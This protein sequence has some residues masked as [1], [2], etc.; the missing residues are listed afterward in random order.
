MCAKASPQH[1]REHTPAQVFTHVDPAPGKS[2]TRWRGDNPAS[3]AVHDPFLAWLALK[4]AVQKHPFKISELWYL[5]FILVEHSTS[6]LD[7]EDQ[8]EQ[9]PPQ[10]HVKT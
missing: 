4:W 7:V 2:P 8:Q 10:N 6:A 1:Q 9:F 5:T 3:I